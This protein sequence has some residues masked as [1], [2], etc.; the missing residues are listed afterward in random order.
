MD[1]ILKDITNLKPIKSDAKSLARFA[2]KILSF[3]NNMEQNG[4][5][6]AES[7]EAQFIMS[8]LSKLDG[9][10][11]IEFGREMV[12]AHK[13]ENITNLIEWLN[14]EATLRSRSGKVNSDLRWLPTVFDKS[15]IVDLGCIF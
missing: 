8:P 2:A 6:I 10:N 1:E 4:C 14:N 11:N 13:V 3:T 9:A 5:S 12:R 7:A 15:N